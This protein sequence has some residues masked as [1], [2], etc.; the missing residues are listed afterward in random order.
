MRVCLLSHT[1]LFDTLWT[2]ARHGPLSMGL[3]QQE[4]WGGLLCPPAEE[5]PDPEI[6]FASLPLRVKPYV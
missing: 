3:S 6:E 4:C 1:W 2:V 5:L